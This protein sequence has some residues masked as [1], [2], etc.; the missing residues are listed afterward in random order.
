MQVQ[1]LFLKEIW[2][3][4]QP[5]FRETWGCEQQTKIGYS[6]RHLYKKNTVKEYKREHWYDEE[7]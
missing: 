4:F 3:E 2:V 1:I 6:L 7:N 5:Q